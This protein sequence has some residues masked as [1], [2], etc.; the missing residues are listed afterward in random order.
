MNVKEVKVTKSNK[1]IRIFNKLTKN[2]IL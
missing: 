2:T 1:S